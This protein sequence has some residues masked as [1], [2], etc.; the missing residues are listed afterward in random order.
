MVE[1]EYATITIDGK[2]L[3]KHTQANPAPLGL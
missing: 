3:L 2:K 1:E